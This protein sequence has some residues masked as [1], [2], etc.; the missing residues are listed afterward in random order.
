MRS[1]NCKEIV[2]VRQRD[3]KIWWANSRWWTSHVCGWVQH[4]VHSSYRL[5]LINTTAFVPTIFMSKPDVRRQR[6]KRV[7][8]SGNHSEPVS[9]RIQWFLPEKFQKDRTCG[10][11]FDLEC[12]GMT[13]R[14]TTVWGFAV[15]VNQFTNDTSKSDCCKSPTL[16][17]GSTTCLNILLL[18][19]LP[20]YRAVSNPSSFSKWCS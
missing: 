15:L 12:T 11:N 2:N 10:D 1:L 20:V 19:R 6:K 4:L 14:N 17:T 8:K 3:S 9:P 5:T 13:K 7:S 18:V 16:F